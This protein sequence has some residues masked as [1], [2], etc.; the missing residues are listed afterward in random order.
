MDIKYNTY[1]SC[2]HT[3]LMY[4]FL[5]TI[6]AY[7]HFTR[8]NTKIIDNLINLSRTKASVCAVIYSMSIAM[9]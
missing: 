4:N 5:V 6:H 9:S 2:M 7:Y 8:N 3:K 1:L